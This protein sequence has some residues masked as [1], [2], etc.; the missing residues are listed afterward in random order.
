MPACLSLALMTALPAPLEWG[1]VRLGERQYLMKD[2]LPYSTV[3]VLAQAPN[4]ILWTGTQEGAAYLAGNKWIVPR[5]L[6][7]L[8]A[9]DVRAMQWDDQGTLWIGTTGNGLVALSAG[10]TQARVFGTQDGLASGEVSALAVDASGVWIANGGNLVQVNPKTHEMKRFELSGIGSAATIT[11]LVIKDP[12]DFMVATLEGSYLL[13]KE[14]GRFVVIKTLT[15]KPTQN[16]VYDREA[17]ALWMVGAEHLTIIRDGRVWREELPMTHAFG[18]A[19]SLTLGSAPGEAW[20]GSLSGHVAHV[21]HAYDDKLVWRQMHLYDTSIVA[22]LQTTQE[23]EHLWVGTEAGLHRLSLSGFMTPVPDGDPLPLRNWSMSE[24]SEGLWLVGDDRPVLLSGDLRTL[25]SARMPSRNENAYAVSATLADKDVYIGLRDG[26][27]VR[28]SRQRAALVQSF[29]ANDFDSI[30]SIVRG[31]RG[32]VLVC[33]RRRVLFSPN[34]VAWQQLDGKAGLPAGVSAYG[35][36]IATAENGQTTIYIASVAGLYAQDASGQFSAV[37]E[38]FGIGS[39]NF[40][41]IAREPRE[42]PTEALWLGTGG[43]GLHRVDLATK[44][45][46]VFTQASEPPIRHGY[47]NAIVVRQNRDVLVTTNQGVSLLTRHSDASYTSESFAVEDGLP[48]EDLL[49]GSALE[50]S[51]KRL[52]VGSSK[53]LAFYAPAERPTAYTKAFAMRGITV[54]NLAMPVGPLALGYEQNRVRFDFALFGFHRADETSYRSHLLGAEPEPTGFGEEA[55]RDFTGL[56][57]GSYVFKAWSRDY[58]GID[59]APAIV[60]FEIAAPPWLSWWAYLAYVL[61]AGAAVYGVAR[62]RIEQL[63]QRALVLEKTVLERTAEV[64]KQAGEI[65]EQR[66]AITAQKDALEESHKQADRIFSALAEALKGSL[67]DQ[68]YRLEDEIGKGGFGVVY[69]A[70]EVRTGQALAVKVF[71]PS[72]GNDS[73]ESLER[74]RLEGV[75]GSKIN[76]RNAVRVFGSGVSNENVAYMAME[77]LSGSSLEARLKRDQK[78]PPA[79]AIEFLI[80]VTSAL[81]LAHSLGIIHRDIKPE[82]IFLHEENGEVI[83]KLLDFGVAKNQNNTMKSL[84]MTG[85]V[86]G[87]PSYIAPERLMAESFDGRSDIYS[88]GVVLYEC[89]SGR[90]PFVSENQNLFSLVMKAMSEAPPPL[91]TFAPELPETVQKIVMRMIE[92]DPLARPSAAELEI[93]L[94]VML[95]VLRRA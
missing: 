22:L 7:S 87:T 79:L 4:G 56:P 88:L 28:A 94:T 59:S 66:D 65:R 63:K 38:S 71:R 74:F 75:S 95:R 33:T 93:E 53:G 36:A 30:Q 72:E 35:A 9:I 2:G 68:R 47:I 14:D 25:T 15:K 76:H 21:S 62:A 86:V 23:L 45:H 39:A 32:E 29:P 40:N 49:V 89:L 1:R 69:R 5:A 81:A 31:S 12:A 34:G 42:G 52:F 91:A 54:N 26:K 82:N 10:A 24:S 3:M 84:T 46:K 83:P 60:P 57:H 50:D 77:L 48:S 58:R 85:S 44:A 19:Y 18:T 90:L 78:L 73:A 8:G 41:A 20:I 92:K 51:K 43:A 6:S 17:D 13:G 61:M 16:L 80:P 64:R 27:L 67:L 11:S 37:H 70:T 55:H